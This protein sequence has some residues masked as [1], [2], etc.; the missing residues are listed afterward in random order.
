MRAIQ[1]N[2][3]DPAAYP[4]YSWLLAATGRNEEALAA[5]RHGQEIDPVS[6]L[7][8]AIVG[9]VLV[10]SRRPDEAIEQ[11]RSARDLDAS[12]W[13]TPYFMGFAY[14]QKGM[15]E[16]ALREFQRA[17]ELEPDNSENLANRGFIL[18]TLGKK[19]EARQVLED[20]RKRSAD[21]Y[22][23]PYNVAVVH[24]GL[25]EKDKAFSRFERA[26]IERSS[27]LAILLNV[28]PRL[29]PGAIGQRPHLDLPE[30]AQ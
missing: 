8:S 16:E 6:P 26:Y 13:Y 19:T 4:F 14:L 22:V 30:A 5:A 15:H 29:E 25:G 3:N 7:L 1:L 18:A 24:V 27:L 12:F 20:L 28:D 9:S 21:R 10:M 23:A 11:L 17:I 2:P